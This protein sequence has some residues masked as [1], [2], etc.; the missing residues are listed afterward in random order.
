MAIPV[1]ARVALTVAGSKKLRKAVIG[2]ALGVIILIIAPVAL[3]LS[4][5]KSAADF[6]FSSPEFMAA[7]VENLPDEDRQRLN[8]LDAVM[9]AL[10]AELKEQVPGTE[11]IKVQVVYLCLFPGAEQESETFAEDFISCFKDAASDGAIF[12]NLTEMFGISVTQSE[13]D[14]IIAFYTKVIASRL[15]PP[16]VLHSRIGEL[17]KNSDV[18]AEEGEFLSPL[19]DRDYISVITSGYGRRV[20]PITGEKSANH[21]GLDMGIPVGTPIYPV[22]PGKVVI[23]QRGTDGYGNYIVI[24]HGGGYASLYGH[25]S[26]LLVD[27]GDYAAQDTVIAKSGNSGRS[28]GPHLHLEIIVGG[29][30]MDPRKYLP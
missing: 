5:A 2:I 27:I 12:D 3:F 21:T 28:T 17:T 19:R 7:M 8:D 23:A 4:V 10:E 22:K 13:R 15:L 14:E 24:D 18:P 25:C 29:Q 30:P 26:D 9:R 16:T 6:N 1:A 11:F 20:D